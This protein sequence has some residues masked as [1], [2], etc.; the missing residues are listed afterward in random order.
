MATRTGSVVLGGKVREGF[1]VDRSGTENF[2]EAFS[3]TSL[4]VG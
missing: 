1:T 4:S 2:T 3:L